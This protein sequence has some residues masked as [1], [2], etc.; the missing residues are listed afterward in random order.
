[1]ADVIVRNEAFVNMLVSSLE[2]YKKE[3][4]GI[5]LG[6]RSGSDYIIRQAF[7]YQSAR[8]HYDWVVI[9]PR[10]R[11]R[12]DLLLRHLM[13]YQFIGDYHSHIDWPSHL[14][15]EDKREMR[16]QDIPLSLL[17]LVK[18]ARRR[19]KWR[20]L[21]SD[22]SL[23]GTVADRY[24]VKL[25]A[26]EYDSDQGRIRKLRVKCPLI[27]RLNRKVGE[28]ERLGLIVPRNGRKGRK[29]R[30]SRRGLKGGVG[31]KGRRKRS[32]SKK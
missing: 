19:S 4:Y 32:P 13:R 24:F 23:T 29:G 14:S 20:F 11:N 28:L 10:R 25:Y 30:T 12:I 17:L 22:Q 27:K 2:V 15:N 5:L 9:D 26:F 6:K 18:D 3:A 7:T 16:E 31:R 21:A 1:M 8:R